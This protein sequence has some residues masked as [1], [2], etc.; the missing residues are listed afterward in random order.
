MQAVEEIEPI[1]EL[2]P[3]RVLVV[4]DDPTTLQALVLLLEDP[5]THVVAA[6][7]GVEAL[8]RCLQLDFAVIL[9]DVRMPDMDGYTT[10]ACIHARKRSA[11]TPIIFL[12]GSGMDDRMQGYEAGAVDFL[13]K[14]IEPRV[15]QAKVRVFV[16]LWRRQRQIEVAQA[17]LRRW[18]AHAAREAAQQ[19]VAVE[20]QRRDAELRAV[21]LREALI[22]RSVPVA[23]FTRSRAEPLRIT[24]TSENVERV[25]GYPQEAFAQDP[26][27]WHS[28]LHPED[29]PAVLRAL[30]RP[31][32]SGSGTTYRWRV[33]DGSWRWVLEHLAPEPVPASG[34]LS[35]TW[36][37][38]HDQK[39]LE[40]RL[41][42]ANEALDRRVAERTAD[43]AAA[44]EELESFSYTVAHD[45]RAPLR[46]IH[47]YGRILAENGGGSTPEGEHA[48]GRLEVAVIRMSRLID[49]LLQLSQVARAR[50]NRE[51][52]DIGA[53]A[54]DIGA[55]LQESAPERVVHLVVPNGLLV[56]G[57]RGLVEIVLGNL[58]SNAWKFTRSQ[59]EARIE[60]SARP[61]EPHV[62]FV[63]DN[64]IGF[65]MAY[66][67]QLF[68]PFHRLVTDSE[69]E[70][71]GIGLATVRRAIQRHGG[72]VW[73][74]SAPSAGATFFFTLAPAPEGRFRP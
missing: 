20:S 46:S 10:A 35:G 13:L 16:E 69:V 28:R 49:D 67:G 65:D 55:R 40:E 11:S 9:L 72:E 47:A 3:A 26:D 43:L 64:G 73:A 29:R 22:F 23:V 17:A 8:R 58:L 71:T 52:I 74:E 21:L 70:G 42:D 24:W 44:V 61:D 45:L 34:E 60:V 14:P 30:E 12:T 56:R 37:D 2:E 39:L 50:V 19:A 66:A 36:V 62:L 51:P 63:R 41:R 18:E 7:S 27:L 48:L 31:D 59:P 53:L 5:H 25:L 38:V 15:L 68:R 1:L 33:A 6:S 4:D 57:D 54:R 32:D